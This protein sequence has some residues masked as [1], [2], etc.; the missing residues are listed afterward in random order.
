MDDIIRIIQSLENLSVLID[1]IIET[2]N[3]EIKRRKG[4]FLGMLLGT[5]GASM[6]GNMLTEKEAWELEK[7]L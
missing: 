2:V 5:L 3:H 6:L 1:G 7:V 4:G